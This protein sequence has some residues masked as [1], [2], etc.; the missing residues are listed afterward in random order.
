MLALL[1]ALLAAAGCA[2]RPAVDRILVNGGLTAVGTAEEVAAAEAKAAGMKLG[3]DLTERLRAGGMRANVLAEVAPQVTVYRQTSDNTVLLA[4]RV[5]YFNPI[6]RRG[7]R[8]RYDS[9]PDV[10]RRVEVAARAL[11]NDLFGRM[12]REL[13]HHGTYVDLAASVSAGQMEAFLKEVR[14]AVDALVREGHRNAARP[15]EAEALTVEEDGSGRSVRV[16]YGTGWWDLGEKAVSIVTD[17]ASSR[18]WKPS[19]RPE[20]EIRIGSNRGARR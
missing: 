12:T 16:S 17:R 19:G 15:R 10:D 7:V 13:H 18:G 2:K 14:S 4:V 6:V 9:D 8:G 3:L 1:V 5:T 11:A 20:P